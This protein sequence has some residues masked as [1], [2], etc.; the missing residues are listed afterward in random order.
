MTLIVQPPKRQDSIKGIIMNLEQNPNNSNG[1][2]D[3][4]EA[5]FVAN[6][7]N[8]FEYKT[9]L[10]KVKFSEKTISE[11]AN[12]KQDLPVWF[13]LYKATPIY[14]GKSIVYTRA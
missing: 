2:F 10:I 7:L 4:K 12:K 14:T 11:Y 1:C 6:Q 13:W 8:L 9:E 5:E 3:I